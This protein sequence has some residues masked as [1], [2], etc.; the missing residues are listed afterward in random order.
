VIV[1]DPGRANIEQEGLWEHLCFGDTPPLAEV[2]NAQS[3][4]SQIPVTSMTAEDLRREKRLTVNSR[5]Q[6]SLRATLPVDGKSKLPFHAGNS[7]SGDQQD[8]VRD[9]WQFPAGQ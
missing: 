9:V 6:R 3:A 8:D 1:V 4:P 7:A 2:V 5:R